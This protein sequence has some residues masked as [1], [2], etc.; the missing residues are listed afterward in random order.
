VLVY[1]AAIT[2]GPLALGVS[3]WMTSYALSASRGLV[4]ALPD[5]LSLLLSVAQFGLLAAT[6][7][8]LFHFV[9]NAPVRWRHAW[10]GALFVAVAFEFAKDVLGWYLQVVPAY[11][12]IYGTF[13]SVPILL[14]WIYV[15]WVLVLLGAVI[16]AYAPSLAMRVV[17]RPDTPGHGFELAL[18]VLAEFD[19]GRRAGQGGFNVSQIAERLRTDPLQIDAVLDRLVALDWVGRLDEEGDPRFTLLCDPAR[20][21]ARALID[22]MLL[23]PGEASALFRRR[24]RLDEMSLSELL[25]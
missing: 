8:G 5:S 7:A 17:R 3:L 25:S 2:L 9:P 14:L 1:W 15:V 18:A 10:A 12:M 6:M 23:A 13:A 20:T 4:G 11:S 21:P 22:G 24:T 16:A 19:R